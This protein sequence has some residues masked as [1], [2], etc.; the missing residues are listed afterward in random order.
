VKLRIRWHPAI[1]LL[2]CGLPLFG[3]TAWR[4]YTGGPVREFTLEVDADNQVTVKAR[5]RWVTL[6]R[7]GFDM[8]KD[9]AQLFRAMVGFVREADRADYGLPKLPVRIAF[10]DGVSADVLWRLLVL[11]MRSYLWK[12]TLESPE[13]TVA[14]ELVMDEGQHHIR[15]PGKPRD[16]LVGSLDLP[17]AEG[18]EWRLTE[19]SFHQ[20]VLMDESI[21]YMPEAQAKRFTRGVSARSIFL[22]LY[23]PSA[24][25]REEKSWKKF[26][27]AADRTTHE[28]VK[29]P[30]DTDF[31]KFAA[32]AVRWSRSALA[33]DLVRAIAAIKAN[34]P[35]PK[36][37][38]AMPERE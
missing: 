37:I 29:G 25:A 20:V 3:Y 14:F 10:A 9:E 33:R 22:D 1:V 32:V 12:V 36:I 30:E 2:L 6:E 31:S 13:Q 7:P 11:V 21:E 26:A 24:T 35:A 8:V 15:S 34:D 4:V 5:R 28:S 17:A 18:G 16:L 23:D 27:G 38:L 19:L